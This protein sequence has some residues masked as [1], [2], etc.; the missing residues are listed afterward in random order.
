[1]GEVNDDLRALNVHLAE[2]A[3]ALRDAAQRNAEL[4]Q[5]EQL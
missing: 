3:S 5:E 1:M 2:D 4:F